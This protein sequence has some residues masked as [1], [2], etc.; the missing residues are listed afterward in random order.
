MLKGYNSLKEPQVF[1]EEHTQIERER[2]KLRDV[3]TGGWGYRKLS[4]YVV[5]TRS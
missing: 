2:E 1:R 4:L 3:M 5:L